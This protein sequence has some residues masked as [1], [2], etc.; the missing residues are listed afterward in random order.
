MI[1][2]EEAKTLLHKWAGGAS[3]AILTQ[4]AR[5][6]LDRV[7]K[8][9]QPHPLASTKGEAARDVD[10]EP[11][12]AGAIARLG[13]TRFRIQRQY[14]PFDVLFT[15]D[16]N[17]VA[18][19]EGGHLRLFD[20]STGKMVRPIQASAYDK[21][22]RPIK[23][24]T[25]GL[26][27]SPDGKTLV[28]MSTENQDGWML[29]I[30]DWPSGKEVGVIRYPDNVA[31]GSM[32]FVGPKTLLT[33]NSDDT[34]RQWDLETKKE[35]LRK[36][37]PEKTAGGD[38]LYAD[39]KVVAGKMDRNGCRIYFWEWQTDKPPRHLKSGDRGFEKLAFS[40]DGKTLATTNNSQAIRL[41]DVATGRLLRRLLSADENGF[42][43]VMAFSPDGKTLAAGNYRR[44]E[45]LLWNV[46]TGKPKQTL[47]GFAPVS[48]LVFSA[49]GKRLAAPS[50]YGLQI[51]DL[52]TGTLRQKNL[53]HS[54]DIEHLA[55]DPKG[56]LIASA[57]S[58][59]TARLWEARTG[60][61]LHVL[62][63]DAEWVR[64]MAFA[65]DGGRLATSGFDDAVRVW[66]TNTGRQV[67]KLVGHSQLGGQRRVAFTPDGRQLLSWGDDFY[68]RAFD[69]KTGKA[70]VEHRIFPKGLEISEDDED[71]P[72]GRRA[73]ELERLNLLSFGF[74]GLLAPGGRLFALSD[75][76]GDFRFFDVRIGKEL[77]RLSRKGELRFGSAQA[78]SPDQKFLLI[79]LYDAGRRGQNNVEI[80][81]LPS[82]KLF[83][84]VTTPSY[85]KDL[86]WAPDGRSFAA[87]HDGK[88]TIWETATGNVRL[89]LDNLGAAGD[90]VAFSPDGRLLVV[91]L[92]DT[93]AL[94][95][96][97]AK[98]AEQGIHDPKSEVRKTPQ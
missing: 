44:P 36:T 22:L 88:V 91:G 89:T 60:K 11:L 40:P 55:F 19:L 79:S 93:T 42:F 95:M 83:H 21:V 62:R 66:D 58:D 78:F 45:V 4:E 48:A 7:A 14:G 73:A 92:R 24:S 5:D 65:P 18:L 15:P 77:S 50:A 13:T 34:V 90:T 59:G 3:A 12:P 86:S 76:D 98:A 23:G 27:F 84:A 29:T 96:D 70:V 1:G 72:L 67:F 94:V 81:H 8:R 20:A 31:P 71:R 41:W 97:L 63:H 17:Q 87:V 26:A 38:Q 74:Q 16:Q 47:S 82:R 46:D 49:D 32:V 61:Q 37:L 28:T 64:A 68:L 25:Y 9:P 2:G 75:Q 30:R 56:R 80:W 53:G 33:T 57:G 69:M 39:G 51:W 35:T 52:P 6:T 85:A 10:G 43:T 54:S